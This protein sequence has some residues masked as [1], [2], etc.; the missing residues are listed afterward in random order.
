MGEF[1]LC[2]GYST[3]ASLRNVS[4]HC[5]IQIK[6]QKFVYIWVTDLEKGFT[7][8]IETDLNLSPI[9]FLGQRKYL[10]YSGIKKV[11]VSRCLR[12]PL[13]IS[14]TKIDS[15]FSHFFRVRAMKIFPTLWPKFFQYLWLW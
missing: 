6:M 12:F 8:Y 7:E 3:D 5:I 2:E 15:P 10:G 11:F 14:Q 9:L 4:F 13:K 1:G